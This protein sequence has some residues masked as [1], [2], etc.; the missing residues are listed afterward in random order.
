MTPIATEPA[1]KDWVVAP[2]A[3]DASPTED[4][5]AYRT[6]PLEEPRRFAASVPSP[7]FAFISSPSVLTAK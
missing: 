7:T 2:T 3:I 4:V 5:R 6:G 1:P